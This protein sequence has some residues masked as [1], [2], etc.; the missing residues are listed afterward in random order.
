MKMADID[1]YLCT[2]CRSRL[3]IITGFQVNADGAV[4]DGNLACC[5]CGKPYPITG[6][7][8]RFV[9]AESY[10]SSFG[11]QW[12][13]H[14]KTQLDSFTGQPISTERLFSASGWSKRLE[15]QL[16]LEAGSGAGRFTE[17][18]LRT[19]AE[20]FS[21][22][23]SSAVEA[24]FLNNG[25]ESNLHLFQGDIFE[26]PLSKESFDKVICLG[27][28]QHTPDPPEAFK[29]LAQHVKPGGELVIDVYGATFF[30]YLHWKYALRPLTRRM[31][32]E[33]L[34]R[35]ISA[36]APHVVPLAAA[37][38]R[39]AGRA[40]ARLVPIVEYSHMGLP[41]EINEDWAI[42]DTFDMYSPVHDHPQ[43][44][45]TVNRWFTSEG[46][47]NVSVRYGP[48]GIVGTGRKPASGC[49]AGQ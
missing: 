40:G 39:V 5:S 1:K 38:R 10:A 13:I 22:D 24:N 9:P 12:N 33:R 14:R 23:Y 21:F 47:T 18:L 2:T 7:I 36:I 30:S 28:L 20:V 41:P 16:I 4:I 34:Y 29:K 44:I 37:L 46:F 25:G 48:N 6:G 19:G 27:V 32:K 3:G 42:L 35:L 17:V 8:P 15:G 26:I 11:Y 49:M 45:R 31:D 43:S